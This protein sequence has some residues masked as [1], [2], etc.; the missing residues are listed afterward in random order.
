MNAGEFG[1]Q[2]AAGLLIRLILWFVDRVTRSEYACEV[3]DAVLARLRR[4]GFLA[5][6]RSAILALLHAPFLRA[7]HPF[8]G[9]DW[10]RVLVEQS[11]P[12]ER[13][14]GAWLDRT[15]YCLEKGPGGW[16]GGYPLIEA[17]AVGYDRANQCWLATIPLHCG[18]TASV[19]TIGLFVSSN[20]G[21]VLAGSIKRGHKL[22]AFFSEGSLHVAVPVWAKGEPNALYSQIRVVR[23]WLQDGILAHDD[24]ALMS[25]RAYL[26]RYG[27]II[28]RQ[29]KLV[30]TT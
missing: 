25:T 12:Y 6:L 21:P 20:S 8:S 22:S 16:P 28:R 26:R 1:D 24:G 27:R 19:T 23:Y 3:R 30:V 4:R 13:A 5:A 9:V 7:Q 2:I 10:E 18:G 17:G 11:W 14:C 15:Y 29:T